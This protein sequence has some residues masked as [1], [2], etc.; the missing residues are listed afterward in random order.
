MT[1]IYFFFFRLLKDEQT[2]VTNGIAQADNA[3]PP[4]AR[5]KKW[6]DFETRILGLKQRMRLQ[7]LTVD[8]YFESIQATVTRFN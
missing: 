4:A 7:R 6:R 3:G 5:R 8:E 1:Y 2:A